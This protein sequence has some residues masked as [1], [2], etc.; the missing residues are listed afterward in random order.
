MK[1]TIRTGFVSNSSSSSFI[2]DL[3]SQSYSVVEGEDEMVIEC[4]VCSKKMQ[5]DN[6][7]SWIT[8]NFN[9]SY[10]DIFEEII[11]ESAKELTLKGR[12]KNELPKYMRDVDNIPL[13]LTHKYCP[14]CSG[15]VVALVDV[16]QY[17]LEKS[18]LSIEEIKAKIVKP[19]KI[20]AN[21]IFPS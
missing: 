10:D 14:F 16:Y 21:N 6:Y 13:S 4:P 7:E 12:D 5:L 18:G 9:D 15:K 17:L 1:K 2:C 19:Y 3:T 20:S 8:D 11:E